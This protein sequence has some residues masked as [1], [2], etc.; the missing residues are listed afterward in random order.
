MNNGSRLLSSSI[1]ETTHGQSD[2][3]SSEGFPWE[4]FVQKCRGWRSCIFASLLHQ[5]RRPRTHHLPTVA[6]CG[7]MQKSQS[8]QCQ[9]DIP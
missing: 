5:L 1:S 6:S 4:R 8:V 9:S 3:D 7:G 2:M